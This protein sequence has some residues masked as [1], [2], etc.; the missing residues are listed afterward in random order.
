MLTSNRK[1]NCL[2]KA[3]SFTLIE[4]LVVI[5]II[6]I[7]AAMLLPAL[8]KA[9]EKARSISCVNNLKTIG[10]YANLYGMDND[11]YLV[12]STFNAIPKADQ[13]FTIPATGDAVGG[14][15]HARN[16]Y[17]WIF[18]AAGYTN[19]WR[20]GGGE[21]I[22]NDAL[23]FFCPSMP[24]TR[25]LYSYMYWGSTSYAVSSGVLY[26]APYYF[27]TSE[28][29]Q[30]WFRFINV[31]S[32]S[33]KWYI[34]DCASEAPDPTVSNYLMIPNLNTPGDGSS[35]PYDW[36]R[37]NVNMLHVGGNVSSY[38]ANNAVANRL[39]YASGEANIRYDR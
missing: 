26:K 2:T 19:F 12:P 8:S 32:P 11:E 14:H 10:L 13:K 34:G 17:Y 5:A 15:E 29:N 20:R 1:T 37:G 24:K 16:A 28:S 36:H 3:V 33:S 27:G 7:L 6:A 38:I 9:R 39:K 22:T 4:L 18:N 25:T 31:Q 35:A 30:F 21:S 23:I